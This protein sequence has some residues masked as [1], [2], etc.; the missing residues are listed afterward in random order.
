MGEV[1]WCVA[2]LDAALEP[3]SIVW[4]KRI[5]GTDR[6]QEMLNVHLY[7]VKLFGCHIAGNNI[8]IDITDFADAIMTGKPHPYVYL[9]FGCGRNSTVSRCLA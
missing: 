5:F 7:F 6:V 9:N 1:V 8:P 2:V 3:G 4:P